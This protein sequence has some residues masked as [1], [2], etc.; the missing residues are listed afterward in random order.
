M[1]RRLTVGLLL[2]VF[3]CAVAPTMPRAVAPFV[4]TGQVVDAAGRPVCGAMVYAIPETVGPGALFWRGATNPNG[5]FRLTVNSA[6]RYRVIPEKTDSGRMS[7]LLPFYRHPTL[8]PPVVTLNE[9]NP[10]EHVRVEIVP[11]SGGVA[12]RLTDAP[13]GRPVEG[14]QIS[15]CL[16]EDPAACFRRSAKR[17]DGTFELRAAHLPFT[18]EIAADGYETWRA[19]G[20]GGEQS[21]LSVASGATLELSV[22]LERRGG[23]QLESE[24]RRGVHLNAPAH[25]APAPDAVF[26]HYPRHTRLEWSPVAGAVSYAVEIDFCF[27]P[28]NK[29][30]GCAEPQSLFLSTTQ[31]TPPNGITG[32]SY[33]FNFIGATTGRWRVWA[34][35]A[36]GREG[37]K[38]G[39]RWFVYLK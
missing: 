8:A 3:A 15:M 11:P 30:P 25:V 20:G 9:A 1:S 16:A 27:A 39:W 22:K 26:D 33:E 4:I 12:L 37:F 36:E 2:L 31:P 17:G 5:E 10:A 38:S 14:A 21:P 18:L 23:A 28:H 6:G 24:K 7:Q 35:D 13:T 32:T 34:V 19:P 29:L